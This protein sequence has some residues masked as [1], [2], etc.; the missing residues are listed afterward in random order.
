[1]ED[2]ARENKTE[3]T[4]D[5]NQKYIPPKGVWRNV[6]GNWLFILDGEEVDH[7]GKVVDK[8]PSKPAIIDKKDHLEFPL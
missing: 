4:G 5:V 1:M 6:G 7:S 8:L 2:N 3:N